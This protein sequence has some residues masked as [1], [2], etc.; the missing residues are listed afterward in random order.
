MIETV[1]RCMCDL[2]VV[3]ATLQVEVRFSSRC[4]S[5]TGSCIVQRDGWSLD[6]AIMRS[7]KIG[8]VARAGG[9]APSAIRYY[10]KCGLLPK[11]D[12]QSRQRRYDPEI[13][14]YLEIIAIARHSGM[15]IAEVRE[16][17]GGF[18]PGTKP[19]ARWR[20]IAARKRDQLDT[21]E[22]RVRTMREA[23]DTEF[24]CGCATF[25]DCARGLTRKRRNPSA[26][27]A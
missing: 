20:S 11:P 1:A 9:I 23:L 15:T 3:A 4:I 22:A 21:L 18:A 6:G 12:R 27:C 13:L 16:L 17:L 24:R 14:G 2:P 19:A 8:D 10:E 25:D 26:G 7:L 5:I